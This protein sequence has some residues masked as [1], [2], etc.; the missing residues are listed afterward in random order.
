MS[1]A[2]DPY[3]SW[4]GIPP[5]EQ[6]PDHYRLLGVPR[7]E[8]DADV[9][10]HAADRQMSY[11]RTFRSVKHVN[12]AQKLLNE[13]ATAKVTLLNPTKR[14]AYDAELAKRYPPVAEAAP[15]SPTPA[16]FEQY[17]LL[18]QLSTSRTGQVFKARHQTMGRVVAL[19]V[20]SRE[21]VASEQLVERFVR[22]VKIL[23][24]MSHPNLV[25][26]FEAGRR[27]GTYYLAMEY[28]D[29]NDL[30]EILKQRGKLPVDEAV[31][32]IIQAAAGL[33][34]AHSHGVFHRNVKPSNLL[35]DKQGVVKVVGLGMAHVEASDLVS[36]NSL[37]GELTAQGQVMG[38]YDFMAPE[39][40]VDASSIDA[41][42][43]I[44]SLGC[45]LHALL[46]GRAPYP[47]KSPMQQVMAHRSHPI[48][49]LR[50][51]RADVPESVDTVFRKMMAKRPEDRQ[52]SMAEVIEELDWALAP[53]QPLERAAAAEP[54]VEPQPAPAPAAAPAR[55]AASA[56]SK[57]ASGPAWAS[58][59]MPFA[60][61]GVLTTVIIVAWLAMSA[62]REAEVARKPARAKPAEAT[63]TFDW[64]AE[65]RARARLEIDGLRVPLPD[66]GPVEH[67]VAPG[68]RKIVAT[69][70]SYE[71]F[72]QTVS[73]G[74]GEK[75]KVALLWRPLPA[76]ASAPSEPT[77]KPAGQSE[78][79]VAASPT[80]VEPEKPT[81]PASATPS[82][83]AE[84]PP[85]ASSPTTEPVTSTTPSDGAKPAVP[86]GSA[87]KQAEK[88]IRDTFKE[89]FD[90]ATAPAE[91]LALAKKLLEQSATTT[92]GPDA[93]YVFARMAGEL[94]VDAGDRETA[95]AAA[96]R[97]SETHNVDRLAMKA[98]VLAL[99]AKAARSPAQHKTLSSQALELMD[100][101]LEQNDFNVAASAGK[102]AV[103]EAG[104]ARDKDSVQQAR[105]RTR[106]LEQAMKAFA[107][108]EEA[109]VTLKQKPDDPEANRTVG[110]Y[111]CFVKGDWEKGL[112]KLARGPEGPIRS[113]ALSEISDP[114]RASEQITLADGWWDLAE[115]EFGAVR[116]N[117]QLRAARWYRIAAPNT[118]GL[119]R[120]KVDKRLKVLAPL[121]ARSM[122]E[123]YVNKIDGSVLVLVPAGQF[124]AGEDRFPVE[125]PAYYLGMYEVTNAQY[126]KFVDA[127]GHAAPRYWDRKEFPPQTADHPVCQ[128]SWEDAQAYCQ[129]AKLRL[130]TELEWEKGA[131]GV[132]GRVYPW[133]NNWDAGRCVSRRLTGGQQ[134]A[135]IASFPEGRSP[136]G[137]Y[138]MAGNAFEWCDDWYENRAYDRY[139]QGDLVP[140]RLGDQ[141][142]GRGGSAGQEDPKAFRAFTRGHRGEQPAWDWGFRVAWTYDQ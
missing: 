45:T 25:A 34:Y 9:I 76:S 84:T 55:P 50:T 66:I 11:L 4:L 75:V 21:A 18:D 134:M 81:T 33:G 97:M 121:L 104:R 5:S 126:K 98:A 102:V 96:D 52:Q 2:F 138:H 35:V 99:L 40:A 61:L 57:Q 12:A 64:P 91:K 3:H 72:E 17:E 141:R 70:P 92:A 111:E 8:K 14:T 38:T 30:R 53:D 135:P 32:Y 20:L 108:V 117:M 142:V 79:A 103:S 130:P 7:Y 69:R 94:A 124:L 125:L 115:K 129:W 74:L 1:K 77:P 59:V 78:P 23:A 73:V 16:A 31:T 41:R 132:D 107:Q 58:R 86:D 42:A 112:A 56:A 27:A 90:R 39:Q 83:P 140:P 13:V 87:Q 106:E 139:R 127:T 101:A 105:A 28:V 80:P 19:K 100:Q 60:A 71:P 44:Y 110:R 131:R 118:S 128:L 24:R 62:R 119:V 122:P 116:K 137:L 114:K 48:P 6:P 54:A 15:D 120:G 85:A 10:E 49:S 95:W 51:L 109:T 65:E 46:T 89:D 88:L 136:W 43:D 113:L 37:G 67:R 63:L 26:A 36:E 29:G 123:R 22:K 68:E 82:M 93:Q 47:G 133:G